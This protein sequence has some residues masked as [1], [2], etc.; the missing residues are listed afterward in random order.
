MRK[1]ISNIY[2]YL[3]KSGTSGWDIK[4]ILREFKY[5]WQRLTRGFGNDELWNLDITIAEFIAPRLKA[6]R[7]YQIG[8]PPDLTEEE[9]ETIL[10][11][12]QKGFDMVI[13][14]EANYDE[15]TIK[16][17]KKSLE[18]LTKYYHFLWD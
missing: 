13:A 6:F 4:L 9:W 8:H 12:M 2:Y 14:D 11:E 16:Q 17:V 15:E 3:F 5:Y 1:L 7:S 10:L 18:L